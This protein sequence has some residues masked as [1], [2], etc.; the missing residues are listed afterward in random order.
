MAPAAK[1]L[2]AA[3]ASTN[4][5]RTIALDVA[6]RTAAL[7]SSEKS[8]LEYE[9]LIRIGETPVP[10]KNQSGLISLSNAL[11]NQRFSFTETGY[12]VEYR[13]GVTRIGSDEA[14]RQATDNTLRL[15]DFH[16]VVLHGGPTTKP[17]TCSN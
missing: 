15:G 12:E 2:V 9:G 3:V 11:R 1:P 7:Q 16:D 13:D 5:A 10:S 14:T 4:L 17:D 6:I 8:A